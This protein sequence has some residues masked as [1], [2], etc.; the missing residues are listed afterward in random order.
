MDSVGPRYGAEGERE[1]RRQV[2]GVDRVPYLPSAGFLAV[3]V[4]SE[5]GDPVVVFIGWHDDVVETPFPGTALWRAAVEGFLRAPLG[6]DPAEP[7]V[8]AAA[9]ESLDR[10]PSLDRWLSWYDHERQ[11]RADRSAKDVQSP[12]WLRRPG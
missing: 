7:L 1:T 3:T 9:I 12:F 8:R 11:R 5:T 6:V 4:G 10:F 2:E